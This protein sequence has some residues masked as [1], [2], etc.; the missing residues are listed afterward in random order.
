MDG[1]TGA[2]WDQE[3]NG[4]HASFG[5]M[6]RVLVVDDE[7]SMRFTLEAVLGD[8]GIEV[9]SADGGASGLLRSR[10]TAQMSF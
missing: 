10:R 4:T 9:E 6:A 7:A 2:M 1:T 3:P 5:P 8:A